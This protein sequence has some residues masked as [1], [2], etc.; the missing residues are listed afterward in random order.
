MDNYKVA[1]SMFE[2]PFD[3]LLFLIRKNEVDIYDIPISEL[4]DQYLEYLDLIQEIDLDTAA[5]FIEMAAT[6]MQIK[7]KMLLPGPALVGEEAEYEED[8]RAELVKQLLT[9]RQFKEAAEDLKKHEE[10]QHRKLPRQIFPEEKEILKAAQPDAEEYLQEVSLFDLLLA[11]KQALDNMPK[12]TTHVVEK[13]D[14]SVDEQRQF[15]GAKLA[16]KKKVTFAELL[17][18]VKQRIVAIVTLLAILEMTRTGEIV[19]RQSEIYGEIFIIRAEG[20]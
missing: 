19:M 20:S 2:G 14:V 3:L 6:L 10:T 17:F 9:Y 5:E 13:Y 8:P 1:L 18:E 15:I 7:A 12:I 16:K 11:L 4:I